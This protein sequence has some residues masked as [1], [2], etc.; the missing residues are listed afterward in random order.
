MKV[1]LERV[2][3][4]GTNLQCVFESGTAPAAIRKLNRF[5]CGL[6]VD[7]VGADR[8]EISPLYYRLTVQRGKV[9]GIITF[10]NR[11]LID[12]S[13]VYITLESMIRAGRS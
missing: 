8:S 9:R 10:S 11:M 12:S 5:Y 13:A 1:T 7:D 2:S 6:C 4:A 3:P